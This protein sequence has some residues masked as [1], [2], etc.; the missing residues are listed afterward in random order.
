MNISWVEK[1]AVL[2]SPL[3]SQSAR[4][5]LV[6]KLILSM[7]PAHVSI[8]GRNIANWIAFPIKV[9]S[10]Y[11]AISSW[12]TPKERHRNTPCGT[13][14]TVPGRENDM[15][16]SWMGGKWLEAVGAGWQNGEMFRSSIFVTSIIQPLWSSHSRGPTRRWLLGNFTWV[17]FSAVF[18]GC[19]WTSNLYIYI[20]IDCL[21]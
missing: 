6:R 13:S 21:Q 1:Q 12:N 11:I 4:V 16:G 10:A 7:K 20:Y 2:T 19:L 3:I 17:K 18:S 5:L 9:H 8:I 15:H 14:A